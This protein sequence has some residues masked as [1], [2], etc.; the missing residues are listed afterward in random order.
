MFRNCENLA[1]IDIAGFTGESA[2]AVTSMFENCKSLTTLNLSGFSFQ[3]VTGAV[4][5][6]KGC[7]GLK[8]LDLGNACAVTDTMLVN[9][10]F[11]DLTNL[12]WMALGPNYLLTKNPSATGKWYQIVEKEGKKQAQEFSFGAPISS[13]VNLFYSTDPDPQVP[14]QLPIALA[15]IEP[16]TYTG[17]IPRQTDLHVTYENQT[18]ILGKDFSCCTTSN[19]TAS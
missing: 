5:M 13:D 17:E 2:R 15:N 4:N 6:L 3:H 18:L 10:P 14:T 9:M 8:V 12:Q 11:S 7:T 19:L 16:Y 1:K